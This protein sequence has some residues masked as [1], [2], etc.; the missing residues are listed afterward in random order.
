[1]SKSDYKTMTE[2]N[3]SKSELDYRLGCIEKTL[4]ELKDVVIENKLQ[5]RD[6]QE[7][8]ESE[9]ELVSAI[10]AHDK[11]IRKLEQMPYEDKAKK[12]QSAADFIFKSLLSVGIAVILAKVGLQG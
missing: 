3:I 12:W 2:E 5:A 7:L 8:K 10:N 9:N 6:I 1:M 4:V 11:R